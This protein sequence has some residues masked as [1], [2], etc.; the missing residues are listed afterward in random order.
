MR[1]FHLPVDYAEREHARLNELRCYEVLGTLSEPVLDDIT[2]LASHLCGTPI[3]L[4]SLVDE[5]RLWFKARTGLDAAEVPRTTAL[6]CDAIYAEDLFIVRDTHRDPRCRDHALVVGPPHVRFYA[7][8]P[9]LMPSGHALGTLC[10]IDQRPRLMTSAQRDGLRALAR[11]VVMHFELQR[12]VADLRRAAAARE[13]AEDALR[14]SEERFQQFM[15]NS[16]AGA[17][18]KDEEGRFVYVNETLARSFERPA[19]QWLGKTDAD[20]LDGALLSTIVEHDLRVFNEQKALTFEE[21]VPTPDGKVRCWLSHKFLLQD[22]D[23][24]QLGGLSVDITPRKDAERERERLVSDLQQALTEVKT[25]SGF[26]PICASCKNIRTDEGY[27]QQIEAYLG[28]H[29]ELE[30]T[31][32]ICPVCL[33]KLYPD[34]MAHQRAHSPRTPPPEP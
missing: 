33:E 17:Y 27:W 3:A 6:C 4:I 34:F 15:N 5:D 16:S 14:K 7:A 31:H 20:F 30:F 12:T 23:R 1:S 19:E 32:G 28:E 8:V 2:N 13:Q 24:K 11:Q 29:S 10:V 9:L 22:G 21:V 26:L 25:L 18:V